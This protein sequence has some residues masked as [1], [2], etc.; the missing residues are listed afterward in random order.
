M[1]RRSTL[2]RSGQATFYNFL[3]NELLA[4]QA[5]E[6]YCF[7]I[8]APWV[9][10]FRLASPFHISFEEV[11]SAKQDTLHLFDVLH[12]LAANGGRVF[13]TVGSDERYYPPLRTL[14]ERNDR[15][16]VRVFAKLHTKAYVGRFGALDGSLNLTESGVHQNVELFHYAHD[17]RS[18]AELQQLCEDHFTRAEPLR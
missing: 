11:V 6:D 15:I 7:W 9:T 12:Q 13:I 1:T 5:V 16:E 14:R 17:P 4:S 8:V 18:R 2:Y 10:N 3:L